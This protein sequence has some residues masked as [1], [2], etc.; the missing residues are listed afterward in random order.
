MEV[1]DELNPTFDLLAE[2]RIAAVDCAETLW[3][4]FYH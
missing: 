1:A 2:V 4:F 3:L